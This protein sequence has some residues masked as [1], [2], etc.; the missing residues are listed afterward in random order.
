M[1]RSLANLRA[2]QFILLLVYGTFLH[3]GRAIKHRYI[4]MQVHTVYMHANIHNTC[5]HACIHAYLL[6]YIQVHASIHTV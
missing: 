1:D 3:L 4:H 2:L 5:M 6:T